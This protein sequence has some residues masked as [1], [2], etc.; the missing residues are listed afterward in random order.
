MRL[1]S[2]F[3]ATTKDARY[4]YNKFIAEFARFIRTLS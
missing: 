4:T 2:Y 1:R 3:Q